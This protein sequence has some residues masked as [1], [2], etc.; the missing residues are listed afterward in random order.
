MSKTLIKQ[1]EERQ[2]P[3][4]L[5]LMRWSPN[6]DLLAI[7]NAKGE[8]SLHRLT[9]QR[10]WLLSAPEDG[11]K[12]K[13]LAWRPDGKLIAVVYTN[14]KTLCMIDIE[15]KNIVHKI[16]LTQ[17]QVQC[18]C[19]AWLSLSPPMET[20]DELKQNNP[21]SCTG[22]YLPPLPNLSRSYGQEP[23]RKEFTSQMLDMLFLGQENGT[24]LMYIFGMFYC[25]MIKIGEGPIIE[26]NGGGGKAL[27]ASW[28]NSECIVVV[29]L[30][31][32]ILQNSNAFLNLA[33]LQAHME[34]L[35]DYLSKSIN[36]LSEA[37]ETI[38]LEMD[39]KI[40]KYAADKAP[41]SVAADFLELLMIGVPSP[42]LKNFLL[43][44][45]TE[46][47]L[48]KLGNSI[49]MC[50]SNIQKLALK[51][52]S[53]VGM[54][55]TYHLSE[56]KGMVRFGGPYEALGLKEETPIT[57]ALS[58]V[59]SFLA[60]TSEVQQVIDHSMRDYRAFITWLYT[61]ILRLNDERVPSEMSKISQQDLTY[62]AEY[63]R[64]FDKVEETASRRKGVNLE[65]L[66]QYLRQD[67]LQTC[68]SPEG[69]EWASM[70]VENKCLQNYP[71]II[72]QDFEG[73]L[74]QSHD[75]LVEAINQVF[76]NAYQDLTKHFTHSTISLKFV[77][78]DT[79]AQRVTNDG[80]LI[81]GAPSSDYKVLQIYRIKANNSSEL[82]L[83]NV[84]YIDLCNRQESNVQ[85]SGFNGKLSDL[86]FYSLNYLTL[87][88][89]NET[90]KETSLI[91]LPLNHSLLSDS[92]QHASIINLSELIES[93]SCKSFND[94]FPRWIAVS[95][96]RK[97]VAILNENK[98]KIRIVETEIENEES[99]HSKQDVTDEH[100]MDT[101]TSAINE[102]GS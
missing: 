74:L 67:P 84:S 50:Y 66:G 47:G 51:S 24:I 33:K 58:A 90:N 65:K 64:G 38:L 97:V 98:R 26:I 62:I 31:S 22:E 37:W 83:D 72:R 92:N 91:Q 42:D 19:M 44:D 60:K 99:E 6:T 39:E 5:V 73:S 82:E 4:E 9:W 61:I 35:K 20:K 78:V 43:R 101:T 59:Q 94:P 23:E 79:F 36:A 1:L 96:Q 85:A 93:N 87:L 16:P 48:K 70:L 27:W 68:F 88:L 69:S 21:A 11:E 15:N 55:L 52:L 34:C 7:A 13:N 56:M 80:K 29:Q 10:V 14:S 89:I 12:I 100:M 53:S 77:S 32:T 86:K 75:T 3:N 41:G 95:G 45:L 57:N 2:L 8:L 25:G 18:S 40:A 17:E 102:S 63:L 76:V 46:K 49:D 81:V 71:L 28:K 54:A 30:S